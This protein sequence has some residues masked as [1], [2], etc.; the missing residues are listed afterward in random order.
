MW[1]EI[2]QLHLRRGA[3]DGDAVTFRACYFDIAGAESGTDYTDLLTYDGDYLG[4]TVSFLRFNVPLAGMIRLTGYDIDPTSAQNLCDAPQIRVQQ[5]GGVWI[6][7]TL[8]GAVAQTVGT[9]PDDWD[10]RWRDSYYT[11]FTMD[12]G[13]A[14]WYFYRPA[15]QAWDATET[16]YKQSGASQTYYTDDG[17]FFGASRY[18]TYYYTYQSDIGEFAALFGVFG[19]TALTYSSTHDTFCARAGGAAGTAVFTSQRQD[20]QGLGLGAIVDSAFLTDHTYTGRL[21][22]QFCEV[23]YDGQKFIGIVAIA[24]SID[25]IPQAATFAGI[26]QKFWIARSPHI[27]YGSGSGVTYGSGTFSDPS[28]PV[29]IPDIPT[30]LTATDLGP[31]M[32]IRAIDGEYLSTL[33]D[34]L[35]STTGFFSKWKNLRFDPLSAIVSLHM[36]PIT[37]TGSTQNEL[38]IALTRLFV[39][40]HATDSR[41]KDMTVGTVDIPEYYGNRLDYTDTQ[42]S[43]FLPYIGDYPLDLQD[44]QGGSVTVRY[45]IDIATGDCIAFVL[46]TDRRGLTTMSK[47]YKGNCAWKIPVSGS[48]NGGAGLLSAL[49]SM[50]GGGVSLATGNVVGGASGIIGGLVE[51]TTAKVNS[52]SPSVQGS[53]SSMGVLTPYIKIYRAAQARPDTYAQITGDVSQIGGTVTAT[54]DG[55]PITGF[56]AFDDVELTV[57]ATDQEIAEIRTLLKGGIYI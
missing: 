52:T 48:D 39:T 24:T 42:A 40:N 34:Q 19:T 54:S 5:S 7:D 45:R 16:Y 57:Q 12:Y 8:P 9:I 30:A 38:S 15:A 29:G 2:M 50:I 6:A 46:G 56:A 17:A 23:D 47:E 25:G 11:R 13:G 26:S 27:N 49:S 36:I 44:V 35:W 10:A 53:A 20:Q 37:F 33:F 51:A 4:N 1:G 41:I 31:G 55:Y 32:H 28:T 18:H 43:I 22:Q 21:L 3:Y 14:T